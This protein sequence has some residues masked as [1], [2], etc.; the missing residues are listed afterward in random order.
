[1]ISLPVSALLGPEVLVPRPRCR[2][3]APISSAE[4]NPGTGVQ[5]AH[6]GRL[7]PVYHDPATVGID[8]LG[9][10]REEQL[11]VLAAAGELDPGVGEGIS[12][13]VLHRYALGIDDDAETLL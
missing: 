8:A 9:R 6:H 7:S 12:Y 11:V 13:A 1:M 4:A 10:A 5:P 3:L 2:A